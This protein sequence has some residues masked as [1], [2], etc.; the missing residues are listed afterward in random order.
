MV[1][2][3]RIHQPG[4][5]PSFVVDDVDV[6]PPAQGEVRVKHTAIG[7]NFIDVYYR[8]G[9]YPLPMPAIVG[10]EAAGVV[11]AVGAGVTHLELG[12]RVA[13]TWKQ[14]G[15]YVDERNVP[16]IS[17]LSLPDD[18]ADDVADVVRQRQ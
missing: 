3:V 15:A 2:A 18:I 16:A 9:A 13:D 6:A 12:A 11:V 10:T 7:V 4:P 14:P 8:T 5:P 17:L 1:R